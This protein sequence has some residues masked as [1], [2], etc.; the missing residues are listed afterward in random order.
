MEQAVK[1][2]LS[3]DVAPASRA[4]L[5]FFAVLHQNRDAGFGA[6]FDA[7]RWSGLEAEIGPA[8]EFAH[9]WTRTEGNRFQAQAKASGIFRITRWVKACTW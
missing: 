9:G 8:P 5:D 3:S 6:G 1:P 2:D 4:S 7:E